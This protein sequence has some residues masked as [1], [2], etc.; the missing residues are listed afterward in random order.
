LKAQKIVRS[1]KVIEQIQRY[2][3]RLDKMENMYE[4]IKKRSKE[5]DMSNYHNSVKLKVDKK[6]EKFG[7]KMELFGKK[8]DEKNPS[9]IDFKI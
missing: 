6:L 7:Q 9:I 3:S 1:G 8:T 4:E 2:N 5:K